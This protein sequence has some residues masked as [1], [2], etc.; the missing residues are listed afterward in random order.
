MPPLLSCLLGK[1]LCEEPQREDHWALRDRCANIT[2]DICR[3]F[4]HVYG[5][6]VPRVAKTMIKTFLDS[7]KPASSH[8]GAIVGL[9]ALGAHAVDALLV[10]HMETYIKTL[11]SDASREMTDEEPAA[12]AEDANRC[13]TALRNA[14][15]KWLADCTEA[16]ESRRS[17]IKELFNL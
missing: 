12:S 8:Y 1:R 2:A 10:E 14:A 16:P 5:N 11:E 15:T 7:T 3:K 6:L 9:A 13:R 4:G 17:L